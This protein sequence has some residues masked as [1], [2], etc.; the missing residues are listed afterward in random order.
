MSSLNPLKSMKLPSLWKLLP[1]GKLLLDTQYGTNEPSVETGNTKI[2]GM[3]DI[4]N[5]KVLLEDLSKSNLSEGERE[6]YLL[7]RGDLLLNR[8]NSY[9]LVGKVGLFDS[10]EEAAFA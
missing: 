4:Q 1:V 10:D 9:D 6:S 3:K 8:T 2:V 7:Y 5:G